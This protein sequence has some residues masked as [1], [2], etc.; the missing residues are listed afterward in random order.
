MRRPVSR[1]YGKRNAISCFKVGAEYDR[2]IVP[3]TGGLVLTP[4][5]G[6]GTIAS[7]QSY[8]QYQGGA[9][10]QKGFDRLFVG[11]AAGVVKTTYD[12]LDTTGGTLSQS[13]RDNL[14]TTLSGRGGYWFAPAFYAYTEA[15][16]NFRDYVGAS[17]NSQGYRVVAGLG[18]DRI[19]LFRGE[20]YGGYQQQIYDVP[21]HGPTASP[22]YG[23]KIFWY[24]TP[25][26]T[27][28]A[29]LNE[30]YSESSVP[31]PTNPQGNPA[32]VTSARLNV[33]YQLARDWSAS[34]RGGFD[35]SAYLGSPRINDSWMAGANF[36]Y[37]VYRN[38]GVVLD[39]SFTRVNSNLA[40][41]SYSRNAVSLGGTYRY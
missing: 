31:T 38:F 20:I 25:A 2:K 1:T 12:Q 14:V 30:T 39:Y 15:V 6:I 11:L 37:E 18:S 35:H 23:G 10:V 13:Y 28:S 32:L 19:S 4:I 7:S 22:V 16:G 3:N 5:G 34:L 41:S 17:Y 8:D 36:T 26:W 24:P 33:S 27:V 29:Q 9:A 21:L 40:F